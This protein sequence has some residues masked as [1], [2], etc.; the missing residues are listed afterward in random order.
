MLFVAAYNDVTDVVVVRKCMILAD[1][2]RYQI[3]H[4]RILR[5]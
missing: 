2:S 5:A 4:V 3:V 1:V